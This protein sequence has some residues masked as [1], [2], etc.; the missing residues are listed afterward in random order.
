MIRCAT[1]L[2]PA[3]ALAVPTTA[4]ETPPNMTT[5][6]FGVQMKGPNWSAGPPTAEP[7]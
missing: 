6:Y 1:V 2:L 4:S 7:K 3:G 5:Y